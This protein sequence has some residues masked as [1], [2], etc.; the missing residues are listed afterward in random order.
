MP[1]RWFTETS[2]GRHHRREHGSAGAQAGALR[3][4]LAPDLGARGACDTER[5]SDARP[6]PGRR[7]TARCA[8]VAVRMCEKEELWHDHANAGP[9]VRALI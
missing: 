9:V 6:V 3:G 7:G 1:T 2:G 8:A 5:G 4:D